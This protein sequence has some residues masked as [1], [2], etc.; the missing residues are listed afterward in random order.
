MYLQDL[1]SQLVH[2]LTLGSIK[3]QQAVL[4]AQQRAME[5]EIIENAHRAALDSERMLLD[6][7][8]KSAAQARLQREHDIQSTYKAKLARLAE[9]QK[10]CALFLLLL[11]VLQNHHLLLTCT[12]I[13]VDMA[14]AHEHLSIAQCVYPH[15]FTIHMH[16]CR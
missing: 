3:Q 11:L 8:S 14:F 1:A 4:L 10:V 2:T 15:T 5:R 16:I 9:L 6:L 7:N 12:F 13:C